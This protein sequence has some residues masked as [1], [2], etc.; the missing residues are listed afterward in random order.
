M[1]EDVAFED[2]V[3]AVVIV[4]RYKGGGVGEKKTV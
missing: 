1:G 4:D 3:V 2:F